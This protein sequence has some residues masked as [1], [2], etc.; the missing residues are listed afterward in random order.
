MTIYGRIRNLT[1][2]SSLLL[3]GCMRKWN[4]NLMMIYCYIHIMEMYHNLCSVL[5]NSNLSALQYSLNTNCH[6]LLQLSMILVDYDTLIGVF[7]FL[8]SV[9]FEEILNYKSNTKKW[10]VKL[11]KIDVQNVFM[12]FTS[13][14][15]KNSSRSSLKW[16]YVI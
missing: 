8:I 11:L 7:V 13:L 2:C 14:I 16:L 15:V 5:E 10:N 6:A 4:K 9:I 1:A 12:N 3:R